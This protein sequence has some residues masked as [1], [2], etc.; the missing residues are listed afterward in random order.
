M[1][2]RITYK[3]KEIGW[4]QPAPAL[5]V[6]P[7][8]SRF[9]REPEVHATSR[10]TDLPFE[11]SSDPTAHN[12]PASMRHSR[13][14][15][16][17]MQ[18]PLQPP[19]QALLPTQSR[20][21]TTNPFAGIYGN[22]YA[23]RTVPT[24][25]PIDYEKVGSLIDRPSAFDGSQTG[26]ASKAL[27]PLPLEEGTLG[28]PRTNDDKTDDGPSDT[29]AVLTSLRPERL[30]L[31]HI[32]TPVRPIAS[33][34]NAGDADATATSLPSQVLPPSTKGRWSHNVGAEFD[35]YSMRTRDWDLQSCNTTDLGVDNRLRR[36]E[37]FA[38][39]SPHHAL[40]QEQQYQSNNRNNNEA[41]Y[42]LPEE[43]ATN[44]E[45]WFYAEMIDIVNDY[46][47]Q[48]QS[49]VQRAYEAGQISEEHWAH[50]KWTYRM[51]LDRKLRIAEDMSGYKVRV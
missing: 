32:A 1:S 20:P 21:A 23:V 2:S 40:P 36:Q 45:S 35:A 33:S 17:Y 27:P 24:S 3:G 28:P 6:L 38:T 50:E 48:L 7:P 16:A 26:Y 37:V 34:A 47:E 5:N 44:P 15:T 10:T 42:G 41:V 43:D 39:R 11:D 31:H 30:S 22:P 49:V 19:P 8:A 4:P 29:E 18:A 14:N 46:H 25:P 12:S 51:A 13:H 9:V